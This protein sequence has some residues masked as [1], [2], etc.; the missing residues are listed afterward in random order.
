MPDLSADLTEQTAYLNGKFVPLSQA[1]LSVFDI[2]FVQGVTV[3][4]Q[5]RTFRGKLFRLEMH[6]ERLAHS[7]EIVGLRPSQSLDELSRIATDLVEQNRR[8]IDADDDLGATIFIT[9]GM[10]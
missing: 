5:L 4:E 3:A 7:L 8:L 10:S 1:A 9:P 2:G 6:L